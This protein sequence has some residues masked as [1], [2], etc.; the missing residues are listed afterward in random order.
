MTEKKMTTHDHPKNP[1]V[2]GDLVLACCEFAATA[3]LG[4]KPEIQDRVAGCG[5][6]AARSAA[7]VG[8]SCSLTLDDELGR[9]TS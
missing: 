1:D 3:I 5:V 6:F 7:S 2:L 9:A 4:L 8:V